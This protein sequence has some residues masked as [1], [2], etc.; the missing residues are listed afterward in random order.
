MANLVKHATT[1]TH[2]AP[3]TSSMRCC[4]VVVFSAS[5]AMYQQGSQLHMLADLLLTCWLAVA[6]ATSEPGSTVQLQC[7]C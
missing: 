4:A 2:T 1:A 3:C 5:L 7:A 6:A